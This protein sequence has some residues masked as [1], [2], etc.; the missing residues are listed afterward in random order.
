MY[1]SL[2]DPLW[3]SFFHECTHAF[4]L[5][6]QG[7]EAVEETAFEAQTFGQRKLMRGIDGFLGNCV[8]SGQRRLEELH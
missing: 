4:F 2:V 6:F 5:I 8:D 7:E 1:R 3:R